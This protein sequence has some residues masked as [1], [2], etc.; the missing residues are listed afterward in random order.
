MAGGDVGGDAAAWEVV[1]VDAL[2]CPLGCVDAAA[3]GVHASAIGLAGWHVV[4]DAAAHVL[5]LT[6]G[7]HIAIRRV[8]LSGETR[9]LDGAPRGG[10]KCH[11][12]ISLRVGA[13]EDVDLAAF[14]PGAAVAQQ[15][16]CWP[17]AADPARVVCDIEDE[18]TMVVALFTRDSHACAASRVHGGMIH[19]HVDGIGGIDAKET[20]GSS[21]LERLVLDKAISRVFVA[22][23]VEGVE[24][25]GG[26]V[27]VSE[28][29]GRKRFWQE[30]RSN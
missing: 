9:I 30:G 13:F 24:P 12:I 22:E 5:P 10:M 23:E 20:R 26:R 27:A 29:V 21:G 3:N 16:G 8:Q 17:C 15:P 2:R 14:R 19:T 4:E 7:I 11:L 1:D 28:R 18:E 6:W 25:V